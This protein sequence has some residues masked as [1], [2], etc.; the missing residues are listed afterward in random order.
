MPS[1]QFFISQTQ[2]GYMTCPRSHSQQMA[3]MRLELRFS[4]SMFSLPIWGLNLE[5]VSHNCSS[6]TCC[7]LRLNKFL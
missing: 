6:Y 2:K 5:R 3:E 4:G 7:K 1:D